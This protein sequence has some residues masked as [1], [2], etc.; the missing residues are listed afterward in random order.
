MWK[1]LDGFLVA[2]ALLGLGLF[3][4]IKAP[5]FEESAIESENVAI[6]IEKRLASDPSIDIEQK[7]YLSLLKKS[8]LVSA[9]FDRGIAGAIKSIAIALILLCLLQ[10]SFLYKVI[11]SNNGNV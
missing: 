4:Y 8:E 2:I 9:D 3:L 7:E 5:I 10:M 11:K 6:N 1:Y